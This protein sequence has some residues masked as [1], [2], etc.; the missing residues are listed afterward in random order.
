M[1]P[2]ERVRQLP[3]ARLRG[4]PWKNPLQEKSPAGGIG[5]EKVRQ[6]SRTS[7]VPV[8]AVL[9]VKSMGIEHALQHD[10]LSA[11]GGSSHPSCVPAE[12]G[13]KRAESP[14]E[15]KRFSNLRSLI[16]PTARRGAPR[17]QRSTADV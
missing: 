16:E 9:M 10:R 8:G 13:L 2:F 12:H 17:Q 6:S 4:T 5:C 14:L 7:E 3:D 11:P 15:P 1:D